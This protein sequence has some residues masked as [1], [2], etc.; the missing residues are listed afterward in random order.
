MKPSLVESESPRGGLAPPDTLIQA[1]RPSRQ[2]V[3]LYPSWTRP[4]P[5]WTTNASLTK[6]PADGQQQQLLVWNSPRAWEA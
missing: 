6:C 2:L 4:H 5:N 3:Y 1:V